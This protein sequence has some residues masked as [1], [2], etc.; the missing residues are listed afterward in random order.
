MPNTVDY[1]SLN[2]DKRRAYYVE[3]YK[4]NRD[5]LLEYQHSY[6]QTHNLIKKPSQGVGKRWGRLAVT[7]ANIA[8]RLEETSLRVE[9]FKALLLA[10][11]S[12][13]EKVYSPL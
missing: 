8:K 2:K 13:N 5:R 11:A 3:Y 7:R 12:N 10:Q 9:R 4:K 6:N 1:L